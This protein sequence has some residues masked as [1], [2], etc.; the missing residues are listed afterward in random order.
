MGCKEQA[1]VDLAKKLEAEISEATLR[2][3]DLVDEP[4]DKQYLCLMAL[5]VGSG[6]FSR[7]IPWSSGCLYTDAISVLTELRDEREA[8]SR[9]EPR[10][11]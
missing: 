2:V 5:M 1:M 9:K 3:T 4:H 7:A 6:L 10:D 11:G 8:R